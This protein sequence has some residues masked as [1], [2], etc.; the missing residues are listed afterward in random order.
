MGEPSSPWNCWKR[1]RPASIAG[2]PPEIETVLDLGIQ[3]AD[4]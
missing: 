3:I 4:A 1:R 2:K